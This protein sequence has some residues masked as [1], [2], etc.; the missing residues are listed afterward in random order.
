[1]IRSFADAAI[2][3]IFNA[4]NSVDARRRLPRK[5]WDVA[6]RELDLIDSATQLDDLRSPPGN[7]L[8]R[9]K[10]DRVGEFSIRINEQY[11]ICFRWDGAEPESVKIV[12]YH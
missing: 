6:F 3:D 9:L 11:R 1:M 12:D 4:V 8:E 10:G 7:R 2:E 5:L